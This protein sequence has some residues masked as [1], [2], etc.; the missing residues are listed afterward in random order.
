MKRRTRRILFAISTIIFF[1]A[2]Y[3]S[4][5]YAQGY[6]YSFEDKKFFRTGAI[7]VKANED[8]KVFIDDELVGT[9]SF[10]GTSF[11]RGGLLPGEYTI[12]LQKDNYSQWQKN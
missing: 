10:L 6:K 9:T 5:L 2:S 3:V 1:L 11:D 12:R 8:A 7:S 4:I